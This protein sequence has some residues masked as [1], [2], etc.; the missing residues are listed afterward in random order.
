[1]ALVLGYA[2]TRIEG[3]EILETLY[4]VCKTGATM[5]TVESKYTSN[6]EKGRKWK[7]S[8]LTADTIKRDFEFI[9]NYEE[10]KIR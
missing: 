1:M 10:P 8:G 3:N 2:V 4:A 5:E 6:F 9:G 7:M